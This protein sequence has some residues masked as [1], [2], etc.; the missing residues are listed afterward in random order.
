MHGGRLRLGRA[1]A[2]GSATV[3]ALAFVGGGPARAFDIDLADIAPE[4]IAR[5][6]AH[7]RG[8]LPLPGTP[9]LARLDERLAAKGLA[10]GDPIFIRIF[11]AS[12]ELELWMRQGSRYVLLDTYPIC[13]WTGTLGP[14]LREGDKQSPEGFY[15]VANPQMRLTGRW[16]RAFD[17]GFPNAHDSAHKRTGSHIL[18]HGGCSST[19]CFAMTDPVQNEI[20]ALADA[21]IKTGQARFQVH[22]FPF[23]LTMENL[24]AHQGNPWGSF[25]AELK[26]GYDAFER[27]LVPPNVALCGQRYQVGDG[28]ATDSER[29]ACPEGDGAALILADAAGSA[30]SRRGAPR[31][32]SRRAARLAAGRSTSNGDLSSEPNGLG[33][34][35]EKNAPRI[36]SS[37][38]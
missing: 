5:R 2:V 32:L 9:D 38:S 26:V 19:G 35:I 30:R 18:V 23:R 4:R 22:V 3:L 29:A 25:W 37:G 27:T 11:K 28:E 16:R 1:L 7:D 17:L 10:K 15:S 21:A 8:A 36:V 12:S 20:Y 13:H 6:M 24:T 33:D 14:K 31:K 34:R